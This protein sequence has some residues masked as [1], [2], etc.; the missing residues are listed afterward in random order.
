MLLYFKTKNSR[1]FAEEVTFSM[2]A[3]DYGDNLKENVVH[4]PEYGIDVLKVALIYGANASGK[5]NL[6]KSIGDLWTIIEASFNESYDKFIHFSGTSLQ[7]IPY[8]PNKKSELN[9]ETPT[10]YSICFYLKENNRCYEY[11][12][13]V[14]GIKVHEES[15][16][17]IPPRDGQN[18]LLF[19][20]NIIN[21]EE[22]K[23]EWYFNS[24]F[25]EKTFQSVTKSITKKHTLWLSTVF[26]FSN[27]DSEYQN[28]L[29]SLI[30]VWLK[31]RFESPEINKLH[32]GKISYQYTIDVLKEANDSVKE[33]L[34][35]WIRKTDFLIQDIL[36]EE[37]SDG[38]LTVITRH[39]GIDRDG[40]AVKVEFDFF[41]EESVG[42]QQFI[43]WIIPFLVTKIRNRVLIIDELGNS[44]HT[45]LT[46]Y[47]IAF[48][49]EDEDYQAQLIF[50]THDVKL[51][52]RSMLRLDQIWMANRDQYG[53]SSIE[54][55]SDYEIPEEMELDNV[56]L[57]G[58]LKGIPRIKK[59][60][61][62]AASKEE[63]GERSL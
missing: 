1:S 29:I 5:S 51:M 57:Q 7:K 60:R 34:L 18:V 10:S 46:R 17:L 53:N 48:M 35:S 9:S 56:Y 55:L 13:S 21:A 54:P 20:R 39:K 33:F 8:Y 43:A 27:P 63:K 45:L 6:L 36:V 59:Q 22:Y 58:V 50:T 14:D 40:N 38:E 23:Y 16:L 37:D 41:E 24:D 52:D 12:L 25:F 30:N 19:S 49:L 44:L 31:D 2:I 62:N 4:I 3:A 61:G 26:Q 32:P 11:N 42:T 28:D 47:L 15:L